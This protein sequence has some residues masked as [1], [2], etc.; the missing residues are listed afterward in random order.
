MKILKWIRQLFCIHKF[1]YNN[2]ILVRTNDGH[3]RT[4]HYWKCTKCDKRKYGGMWN[5]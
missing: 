5:E 4:K 1:Q 3:W 2:T